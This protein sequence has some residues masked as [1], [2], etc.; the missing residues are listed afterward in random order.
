MAGN[1]RYSTDE[2]FSPTKPLSSKA[3]PHTTTTPRP[4]AKDAPAQNKLTEKVSRAFQQAFTSQGKTPTLKGL[5]I[6]V[7]NTE[8]KEA[9][10]GKR[11][12]CKKEQ[13][14]SIQGILRTLQGGQ[15]SLKSTL[16]LEDHVQKELP[17]KADRECPFKVVYSMLSN[18]FNDLRY[19]ADTPITKLD[20]KQEAKAIYDLIHSETPANIATVKSSNQDI[21][22]KDSV[23]S[24]L[25]RCAHGLSCARAMK[26]G[27]TERN[28]RTICYAA[29]PDTYEKLK[30]LVTMLFWTEVKEGRINLKETPIDLPFVINSLIS[31]FSKKDICVPG[32]MTEYKLLLK[33]LNLLSEYAGTTMEIENPDD[34]T[35]TIPVRLNYKI[36]CGN[37]NF[38][39]ALEKA[40]PQS[41]SGEL[42]AHL[43]SDS[44]DD[45]EALIPEN[46][47]TLRIEKCLVKL[48]NSPLS[49]EETL[50]LRFLIAKEAGLP[51]VIH[52]R[53]C[54]DR[55]TIAAAMIYALNQ[56]T[57][58]SNPIPENPLDL[59]DNE[60]FKELFWDH[61]AHAIEISAYS[62][63]EG[64]YKWHTTPFK[65]FTQHPTVLRLMP[66]RLIQS[67]NWWD[68]PAQD[69]KEL[70][71]KGFLYQVILPFMKVLSTIRAIQTKKCDQINTPEAILATLQTALYMTLLFVVGEIYGA[72][73]FIANIFRLLGYTLYYSGVSIKALAGDE[74]S[75]Q[76]LENLRFTAGPFR[77]GFQEK[78]NSHTLN[79][80][81]AHL[82][83]GFSLALVPFALLPKQIIR[84]GVYIERDDGE[85]V[86]VLFEDTPIK[87]AKS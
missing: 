17:L 87:S 9:F 14:N 62:R 3:P 21:Q 40:L 48:K 82:F 78:G 27:Y 31:T 81:L 2:G 74:H 75:K 73:L 7:I 16:S 85:K 57:D 58:L 44:V 12:L 37:F 67:F 79:L 83:L 26:L 59:L 43:I 70:R 22:V 35:E 61:I 49:S 24:S 54:V 25:L 76:R 30:E 51:T 60:D 64:G 65:W 28:L 6:W 53:S 23:I 10:F 66:Q 1:I 19:S 46:K 68:L 86:P 47:M 33:E 55:T 18:G 52:C 63:K 72:L 50:L 39:N 38:V 84:K 69:K 36:Y 42:R 45:L 8:F 77:A 34:P 5:V 13:E 56:W 29:R 20:I 41:I 32:E 4:E 71:E 80:D 15:S 11:S